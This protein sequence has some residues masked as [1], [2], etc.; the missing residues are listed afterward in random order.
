MNRHPRPAPPRPAI[1]ETHLKNVCLLGQAGACAMLD[2]S[3][4]AVSRVCSKGRERITAR[5]LSANGDQH[6]RCTGEPE[7]ELITLAKASGE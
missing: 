7:F 3:F 6:L 1:P 2:F 4:G 5:A